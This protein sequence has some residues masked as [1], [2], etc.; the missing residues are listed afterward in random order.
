MDWIVWPILAVIILAF[1]TRALVLKRRGDTL[2]EAIWWLRARL[3]GRIILFPLAIWLGWHFFLEPASLD[4]TA[5]V[6]FDDWLL[7]LVGIILALFRDYEEFDTRA[8]ERRQ[9]GL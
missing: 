3:W 8:A 7:V 2:S 9:R 4:P 5:G 6:W 1:E